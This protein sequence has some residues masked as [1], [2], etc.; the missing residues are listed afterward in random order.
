M[1]QTFVLAALALLPIAALAQTPGALDTSFGTGGKVLTNF[2]GDNDEVYAAEIQPDGKLIVVG[3]TID[4]L[5]GETHIGLARYL[6]N[7]ALDTTFGDGGRVRTDFGDGFSIGE[8]LTLQPNGKILVG[9][10]DVDDVAASPVLLRYRP[11]GTLDPTFGSGGKVIAAGSIYDML[12]QPDRKI[13]TVA[14]VT[15]ARYLPDGTLDM[16]FGA[17][18]VV[19]GEIEQSALALQSDGRIVTAGQAWDSTAEEYRFAVARYLPDGSI[20]TRF[21][22]DGLV[23]TNAGGSGAAG[24]VVVQ[25]NGKIVT[26]GSVVDLTAGYTSFAVMRHL[27][28]GTLD[29]TFGGGDGKASADFGGSSQGTSMTLQRDG[30]IVVAGYSPGGFGIARFRRNGNLDA[31][32][33]SNGL[34][35]TGFTNG[36]AFAT[37]LLSQ[38]DGRLV[39]AGSAYTSAGEGSF[40]FAL[41]RYETGLPLLYGPP[42]TRAEC[43]QGGWRE[44][45]VPRTFSSERDCVR[46]V[47]NGE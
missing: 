47:N 28:D 34:V 7:G 33:G 30:K 19:T 31:A 23:I 16:S 17:G 40:D 14:G 46:F 21:G 43:R 13:V 29:T 8:T 41:A 36:G 10:A 38:P 37:D 42:T 15:L 32:F 45:N 39:A 12:L 3:Y 9:A 35:M 25:R 4:P 18:G 24:A 6:P 11:N 22:D 5:S 44:F 26:A 1:R 27:E 20:D 2:D